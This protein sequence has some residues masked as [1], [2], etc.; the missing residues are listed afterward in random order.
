MTG[1][2]TLTPQQMLCDETKSCKKCETFKLY[3]RKRNTTGNRKSS[4]SRSIH[5]ITAS[6]NDTLAFIWYS[7]HSCSINIKTSAYTTLVGPL[8]EYI[9]HQSVCDPHPTLA[10]WLH[11]EY[12]PV[13]KQNKS[14]TEPPLYFVYLPTTPHLTNEA[15]HVLSAIVARTLP[16]LSLVPGRIHSNNPVDPWWTLPAWHKLYIF[17]AIDFLLMQVVFVLM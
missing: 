11:Q 6:A 17:K 15:G 12:W 16:T 10:V 8:L 13:L 3:S 2:C 5:Q 9:H 14:T 4:L 7:L 1:K